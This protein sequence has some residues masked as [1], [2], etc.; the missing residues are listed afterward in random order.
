MRSVPGMRGHGLEQGDVW[1][2]LLLARVGWS[3]EWASGQEPW[4]G[5]ACSEVFVLV[6]L[7]LCG[8][9]LTTPCDNVLHNCYRPSGKS[10]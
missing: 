9:P 5:L 7:F 6:S 10:Q 3:E 1:C 8:S 2:E 4:E